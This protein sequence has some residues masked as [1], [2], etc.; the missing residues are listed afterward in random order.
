[1]DSSA[2][3]TAGLTM[4]VGGIALAAFTFLTWYDVGGVDNNAWDALRRTDVVVF[5][6]GLVAAAGGAWL[7]FGDIGPEARVVAF[8]GAAAAG[9]AGLIVIVRMLSPPGD[10]DLKIG[11]FLA[12]L[13]AAIAVIGGLMALSAT[14]RSPPPRPTTPAG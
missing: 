12:L 14:W 4:I 2:P 11:I 3:R 6:G 10:G 1:M 7:A 9:L 8:L 13:A 5:A